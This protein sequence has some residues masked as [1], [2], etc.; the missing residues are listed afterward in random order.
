MKKRLRKKRHL[1][2]FQEFGFEVQWRCET[3]MSEAECEQFWTEWITFVEAR[4]L[5]FGGGNDMEKGSGFVC[6]AG[7][8]SATEQNRAD[9]S[10]WFRAWANGVQVQIGPLEDAWYSPNNQY[11]QCMRWLAVEEEVKPERVIIPPV[12]H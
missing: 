5:T 6:R 9:V 10:D 4:G 2:E 7:R 8:G 1:G 12:R 3:A 11:E